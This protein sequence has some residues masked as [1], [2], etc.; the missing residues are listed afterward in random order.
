MNDPRSGCPD[1]RFDD[2]YHA[3]SYQFQP[4]DPVL[5]A[6]A[7]AY[8]PPLGPYYVLRILLLMK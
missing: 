5:I 1:T 2:L 4:G 7:D 6:Y 8:A 3:Q